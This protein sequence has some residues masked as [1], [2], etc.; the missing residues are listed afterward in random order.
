MVRGLP[1]DFE[2]DERQ[3]IAARRSVILGHPEPEPPAEYVGLALSG[4][5]VRSATFNLGVLQALATHHVLGAHTTHTL[6]AT[7]EGTVE[8]SSTALLP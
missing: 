1:A 3:I 4:G 8:L 6:S 2:R 7:R 5:G